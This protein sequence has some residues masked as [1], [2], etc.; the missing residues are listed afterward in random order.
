MTAKIKRDTC[1]TASITTNN[2]NKI[3]SIIK[4][5][6]HTLNVVFLVLF[7]TF[8]CFSEDVTQARPVYI[9]YWYAVN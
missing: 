4:K 9:I 1:C 6:L 5:S 8:K 2:K 7:T 3:N